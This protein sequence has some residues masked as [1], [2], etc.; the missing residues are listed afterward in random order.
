MLFRSYLAQRKGGR[1]GTKAEPVA[2]V[3]TP[4]EQAARAAQQAQARNE[5]AAAQ[6]E[7]ERRLAEA[8]ATKAE[9]PA[10]VP[11]DATGE[12]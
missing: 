2:P 6:A 7:R 11:A 3:L 12:A 9:A 10:E 4:E 8:K 1:A 5:A